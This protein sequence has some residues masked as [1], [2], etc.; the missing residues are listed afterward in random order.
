[1]D[2]PTR[3]RV[4]AA[5]ETLPTPSANADVKALKGASPWLR[6]RVGDWRILYRPLT[7]IELPSTPGALVA[8][9]VHRSELERT[10]SGLTT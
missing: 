6:M 2:K 7:E 1:M 9:V 3:T 8:R 4:V 10:V 5:L